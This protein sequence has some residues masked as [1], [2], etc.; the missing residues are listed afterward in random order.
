MRKNTTKT[1][2]GDV[3]EQ[4]KK[5]NSTS[6]LSVHSHNDATKHEDI[7]SNKKYSKQINK[8]RNNSIDQKKD[9]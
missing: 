3:S 1:N 9:N 5:Q 7:S 6:N 4:A 2:D 8:G